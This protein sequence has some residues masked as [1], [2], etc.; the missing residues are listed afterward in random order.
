MGVHLNL[1][2]TLSI[3]SIMTI[4]GLDDHD[5]ALHISYQDCRIV[6]MMKFHLSSYNQ[7]VKDQMQNWHK[8]IASPQKRH[9][10]LIAFEFWFTG[11]KTIFIAFF[12]CLKNNLYTHYS[13]TKIFWL[14]YIN[15]FPELTTNLQINRIIFLYAL[16]LPI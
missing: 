1:K 5:H 4:I 10:S 14:S 2:W 6:L 12:W 16:C 11:K 15:A 7:V 3:F 9:S 13:Q 8:C